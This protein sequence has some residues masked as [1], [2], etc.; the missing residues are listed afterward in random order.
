MRG[1][2]Q[3]WEPDKS[4]DDCSTGLV[5]VWVFVAVCCTLLCVRK[6]SGL[7][8]GCGITQTRGVQGGRMGCH[9]CFVSL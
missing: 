2:G 9:C 6:E 8:G 1:K 7:A 4:R 5:L 3:S